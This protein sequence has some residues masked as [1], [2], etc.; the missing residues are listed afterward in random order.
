MSGTEVDP[1]AVA[2][3]FLPEDGVLMGAR[4]AAADLGVRTVSPSAGAA[5]RFLAALL[6]ARSVVE[7]GT[8]AGVS[9]LWLLR[10]MRAEG[11]L[12][13]VDTEPESQRAA[14]DAFTAAGVP[15]NR[16]RLIRGRA[17]EVLPRLTDAGYDLMCCS[18]DPTGFAGHLGEARRLLREGGIV[19]FTDVLL[20][21]AYAD[22]AARDPGTVAMRELVAVLREDETFVVVLLPVGGGLLAATKRPAR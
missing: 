7:I 6:D 10:G 3:A 16:A 14:R 5:L 20:D 21:G 22:P 18:G 11:V 8:G 1:V 4:R 2:D 9:G 15:T 17:R 12:T 13:S 19:A